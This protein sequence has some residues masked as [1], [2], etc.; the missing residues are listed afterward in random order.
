MGMWP[1][2][3]RSRIARR[4]LPSPIYP[5]FGKRRSQ[6]PES[7]G[8]RCV[9]T[10]VIRTSASESPQFTSPLMPHIILV[11]PHPQLVDLGLGVEH[12]DRLK[13]AVDQAG[14]TIEKSQAK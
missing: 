13:S 5:P 12:L 7:S 14:H 6:R 11:S 2:A 4:R 10:F 9:C 1:S 3:E 8:P